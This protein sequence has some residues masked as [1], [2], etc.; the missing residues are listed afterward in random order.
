[1]SHNSSNTNH[2]NLLRIELSE[3]LTIERQIKKKEITQLSVIARNERF[4][5]RFARVTVSFPNKFV[6]IYLFYMLN[7]CHHKNVK[8]YSAQS[9][10]VINETSKFRGRVPDKR[11]WL[12]N[13]S[14]PD[15]RRHVAPRCCHRI[16]GWLIER[17]GTQSLRN[18][19]DGLTGVARWFDFGREPGLA[20]SS[21]PPRGSNVVI[22]ENGINRATR[23]AATLMRNDINPLVYP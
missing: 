13:F 20:R 3:I 5:Y 17:I 7:A 22:R 12:E 10:T 21:S 6:V 18:W 19:H 11:N 9:A 15:R 16:S 1:M 14:S 23:W 2:W 4:E 8:M